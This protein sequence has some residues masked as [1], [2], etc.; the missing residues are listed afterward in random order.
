MYKTKAEAVKASN[1]LVKRL[2]GN[3][4]KCYYINYVGKLKKKEHYCTI[5][6]GGLTIYQFSPKKFL[7]KYHVGNVFANSR[8]NSVIE[9]LKE[10]EGELIVAYAKVANTVN[11]YFKKVATNEKV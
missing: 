9:A 7:I 8:G 2:G 4:H 3:W 5:Q 10:L 11:A 1:E 6:N